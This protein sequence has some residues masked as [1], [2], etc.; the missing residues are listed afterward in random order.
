MDALTPKPIELERLL[1]ALDTVLS[2]APSS[3]G[4]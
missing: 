1:V 2:G 3:M 4:V